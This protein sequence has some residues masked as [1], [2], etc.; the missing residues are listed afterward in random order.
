MKIIPVLFTLFFL[1]TASL[2]SQEYDETYII[3]R[4][5]RNVGGNTELM[6]CFSKQ[7]SNLF[8]RSK[9]KR[10][11]SELNPGINKFN[12]TFEVQYDKTIKLTHLNSL[13]PSLKKEFE[14]TLNKMKILEPAMQKGEAISVAL[15]IP[16]TI[17]T[18]TTGVYAYHKMSQITDKNDYPGNEKIFPRIVIG[19]IYEEGKKDFKRSSDYL[20]NFLF[21][22]IDPNQIDS[23]LKPGMNLFEIKIDY[24]QNDELTKITSLSSNEKLNT[25]FEENIAKVFQESE[26]LSPRKD[27]VA[28]AGEMMFYV[29]Y[30]KN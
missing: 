18:K 20:L 3:A 29:F 24:N 16:I 28:Y 10:L 30:M 19:C 23:L 22:T 21:N 27:D 17:G 9:N 4:G 25:I 12:L 15:H 8:N 14:R 13:N 1:L 11:I 26:F 5:C 6:N 2:Y 7:V